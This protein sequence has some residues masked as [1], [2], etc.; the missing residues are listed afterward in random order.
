MSAAQVTAHRHAR[1]SASG[2]VWTLFARAVAERR[3]SLVVWAL[4]LGAIAAVQ[5]SVYPS[6]RSSREAMQAFVDQWPEAFRE[7]FG[8]GAYASGPGYLNAELFSFVVPF[9]L[10]GVAIGAAA[11]ATA[12][13]EERGTAD[14]LLALPVT[15]G[16]VL[17]AKTLVMVSGV[18]WVALLGWLVLALGCPLVDLQIDQ[19]EL[20]GAFTMAALLAVLFGASVLLV[21]A[22]SGSRALALGVGLGLALAAFL[23]D[24]LAPMADWLRSWEQVSP[25]DWALGNEPLVNGADGGMALRFVVVAAFLLALAHLAFRRRDVA[26]R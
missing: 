20:A 12:G 1:P 11:A 25:F 17:A 24:A 2:Q 9:V 23:L 15:R 8:L 6:V 19:R 18:A 3:R 5:L 21:G 7:A 26:T 16:T 14:L 10:I 4:G 13:E 22:L